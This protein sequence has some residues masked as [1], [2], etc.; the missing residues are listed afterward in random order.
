MSTP[1]LIAVLAVA[2][3]V[4]LL[5]ALTWPLSRWRA[6]RDGRVAAADRADVAVARVKE[7][8]TDYW[9]KGRAK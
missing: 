6:W 1:A 3:F 7:A 5:V 9:T 8:R 2:G 4:V